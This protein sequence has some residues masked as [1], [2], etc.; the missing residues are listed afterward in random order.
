M[1]HV[2]T[3]AGR[4]SGGGF[5]WRWECKCGTAGGWTTTQQSC[6]DRGAAHEAK[7]NQNSQEATK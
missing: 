3:L 4:L 6:R 1:S 7:F 5:E 2:T